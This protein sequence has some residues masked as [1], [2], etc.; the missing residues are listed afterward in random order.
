M[1][2]YSYFS[3]WYCRRNEEEKQQ[4][5]SATCGCHKSNIPLKTIILTIFSIECLI[6]FKMFSSY[7]RTNCYKR[8]LEFSIFTWTPDH[9]CLSGFHLDISDLFIS[10]LISPVRHYKYLSSCPFLK[11]PR[12]YLFSIFLWSTHTASYF[13]SETM[14]ASARLSPSS[15]SLSMWRKWDSDRRVYIYFSLLCMNTRTR[16]SDRVQNLSDPTGNNVL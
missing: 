8:L 2:Q 4:R 6:N 13:T 7:T 11:I 14:D 15:I 3:I 9:T 10:P 12:D 5:T 16:R 1:K